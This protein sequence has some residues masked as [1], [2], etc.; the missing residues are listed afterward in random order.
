MAIITVKITTQTNVA[1][2]LLAAATEAYN[3][4]LKHYQQ[5]HNHEQ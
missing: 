1:R 4:A 3:E 5:I 2:S